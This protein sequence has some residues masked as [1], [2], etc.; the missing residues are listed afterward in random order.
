MYKHVL[1]VLLVACGALIPAFQPAPDAAAQEARLTIWTEPVLFEPLGQIIRDF[2]ANTGIDVVLQQ[3]SQQEIVDW[4]STSND[5]AAGPDIFWVSDDYLLPFG[6]ALAPLTLGDKT[7]ELVPF[8]L[9]AMTQDG[10][11]VAMP[12]VLRGLALFRNTDLVPEAPATWGEVSDICARI[13]G[14]GQAE[15]CLALPDGDLYSFAPVMT[16]FG[17]YV[18][19]TNVDGSVNVN[20]IGLNGPGAV[21]ALEWLQAMSQ[22]GLLKSGLDWETAQVAF[23]TGSA[24]M[25]INGPWSI[26][27]FENAE[28]PFAVS[29]IPAA[30]QPASPYLHVTGFAVNA[31]SAQEDAAQTFVRDYLATEDSIAVLAEYTGGLPAHLT[32]LEK[33]DDPIMV[34]FV[35]AAANGQL[36]PGR[37]PQMA[38]IW[39]AFGEAIQRVRDEGIDPQTAADEAV[40][41]IQ[42]D[43]EG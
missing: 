21:A 31:Y 35:Q 30:S 16:A 10:Q 6:D 33:L 28:I 43:L 8:A 32:A 42:A 36:H 29:A 13:I 3:R 1:V 5:P 19:G 27:R 25:I 2:E 11:V 17:G 40:T 41:Q 37:M 23:E 7:I 9:N 22:G 20:D 24:G 34:G 12:F 15:H 38:L 14:E 18:F 4:F 26:G 39:G